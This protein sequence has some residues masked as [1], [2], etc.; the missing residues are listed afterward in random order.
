M[1]ATL[2]TDPRTQQQLT[3]I[4]GG[5][6]KARAADDPE[7]AAARVDLVVRKIEDSVGTLL[8]RVDIPPDVALGL[9]AR[10]AARI[11]VG[12]RE[13]SPKPVDVLLREAL[14]QVSTIAVAT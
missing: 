3:A 8:D 9:I 5:L 1:P 2:T 14:A 13:P 11:A 6:A 10:L 7:L 12:A 4:V